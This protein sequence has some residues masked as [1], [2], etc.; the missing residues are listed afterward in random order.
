MK[1]S[2][3]MWIKA[4]ERSPVKELNLINCDFRNISFGNYIEYVE[5]INLADFTIKSQKLD[6]KARGVEI[7]NFY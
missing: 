6:M 3:G 2:Y 7:F 4:Y 5:E 1:S